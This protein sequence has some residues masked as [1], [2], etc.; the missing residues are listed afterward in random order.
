MCHHLDVCGLLEQDPRLVPARS[1]RGCS[2]RAG[3]YVVLPAVEPLDAVIELFE[4]A[5]RRLVELFV[6]L[7]EEPAVPECQTQC[8][9]RLGRAFS[10][11]GRFL[12]HLEPNVSGLTT[13]TLRL[14]STCD[15]P[16]VEVHAAARGCT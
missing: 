5:R 15:Q 7:A 1:G 8:A 10:V 4:E 12:A 3:A 13:D 14:R 6:D 11:R 2:R 9:A 16:A